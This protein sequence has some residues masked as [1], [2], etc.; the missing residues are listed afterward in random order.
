MVGISEVC[1]LG[2]GAYGVLDGASSPCGTTSRQH[3]I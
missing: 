3:S 2:E 1:A